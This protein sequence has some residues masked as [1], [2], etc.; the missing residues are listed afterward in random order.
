MVRTEV[1]LQ[2]RF[3]HPFIL[4]LLGASIRPLVIVLELAPYGALSNTLTEKANKLNEKWI[5]TYNCSTSN[6]RWCPRPQDDE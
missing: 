6:A 5:D 2:C 3:Q 1:S 4:Q